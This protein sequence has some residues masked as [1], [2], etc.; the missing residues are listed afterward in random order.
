MPGYFIYALMGYISTLVAAVLTEKSEVKSG[1]FLSCDSKNELK[2]FMSDF[3]KR[4]NTGI[5][6]L[7]ILKS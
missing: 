6:Y 2:D 1:A 5:I 3:F 4:L 7:S